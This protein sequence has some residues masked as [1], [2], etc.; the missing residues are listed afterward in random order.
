MA[1]VTAD[2][3]SRMRPARKY[4]GIEPAQ[5]EIR[6]GDRHLGAAAAVAD[7]P[8]LGTRAAR[9]DTQ[10]TARV[11]P[12]DRAAARADGLDVDQRDGRGQ[13]PLDLV[14]GRVAL[15]SVDEN[16]DI[17]ARA[18]HVEREDVGLAERAA[19]CARSPSC[20]RLGRT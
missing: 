1:S 17:G 3:S 8:R 19:R 5:E 13:T 12:G 11:D 10:E 4:S 20:P 2:G 6:I 9:P 18:A 14:F 15:L 16:A 7:R